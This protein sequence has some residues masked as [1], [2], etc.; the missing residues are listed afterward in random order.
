MKFVVKFAMNRLE[1]RSVFPVLNKKV[2]EMHIPTLL[3][4]PRTFVRMH[5]LVK[6]V[7]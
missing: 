5:A 7:S 1:N 2:F 3:S 4:N 6:L